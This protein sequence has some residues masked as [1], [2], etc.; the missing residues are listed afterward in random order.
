M[1]KEAYQAGVP[2]PEGDPVDINSAVALRR[3]IIHILETERGGGDKDILLD[4]ALLLYRPGVVHNWHLDNERKVQLVSIVQRASKEDATEEYRAHAN[5]AATRAFLADRRAILQHIFSY[6]LKDEAFE[7]DLLIEGFLGYQEGM[8]DYDPERNTQ[9][10]TLC[11]D[12]ARWAVSRYYRDNGRT[13]RL[14]VHSYDERT[15]IARLAKELDR[16]P[17]LHEVITRTKLSPSAAKR[18]LDLPRLVS[19]D[20]SSGRSN[21]RFGKEQTHHDKIADPRPES[22]FEEFLLL[23]ISRE[24]DQKKIFSMLSSLEERRRDM[25]KMRFGIGYEEHTLDEIGAKYGISKEGARQSIN[26]TLRMLRRM[27]EKQGRKTL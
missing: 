22:N 17:T 16:E 14:P 27:F 21:D 3:E 7:E 24:H 20:R 25:I 19:I 1:R 9:P 23:A 2:T 18:I 13:I 4:E 15:I 6:H 10:A 26:T 12:R 11:I 8:V 5:L